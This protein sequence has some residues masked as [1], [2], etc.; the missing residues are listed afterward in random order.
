MV[1]VNS[2]ASLYW[3]PRSLR[4]RLYRHCGIQ[5]GRDVFIFPGQLIRPGRMT[6]GD[7]VFVNGRCTFEPGRAGID[8]E[9]DVFIAQNVT[10]TAATHKIG[11][12]SKRAG[13]VMSRAVI[14]GRGSWI[15]AAAT[16][17]PGVTVAPGCVIAAGA[18][19]T[20]DTQPDGLYVG[21]PA[22]RIRSLA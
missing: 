7:R 1:V 15:G 20:R 6:F 19:V 18:V 13:A 8:I 9:D 5:V 3:M 4:N 17:L 22:R 16:V 11:P 2:V 14:I 21:V 12:P 10:I